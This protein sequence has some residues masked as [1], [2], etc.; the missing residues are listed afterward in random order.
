MSSIL[1]ALKKLEDEKAARRG[2]MGNLA[3][4]VAKTG[5]RTR[6]TSMV[7]IAGGMAAVA[8]ISVLIT[9]IAMNGISSH[10]DN[11][12]ARNEPIQASPPPV[13]QQL[14]T[15]T[16]APPRGSAGQTVLLP[17]E[18]A[19]VIP[20]RPGP[21]ATATGKSSQ[22]TAS[23]RLI[24]P[25]APQ[26]THPERAASGKSLPSLTVSGIAWQ[27][28]NINRMAV[29]NSTPVREEG[30]IEGALVKEILPD[31]VRFSINGKEF[32]VSL[33]K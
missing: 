5:R 25:S 23:R 27:K 22:Q 33:E 28:D 15:G 11:K 13:A 31:R 18:M 3:G 12:P 20:E 19:K 6:Q 10:R 14:P 30:M 8:V 21:P 17:I 2:G 1:E 7:L 4:K 32:D 24:P 9:Y 26:D 16:S 29:V